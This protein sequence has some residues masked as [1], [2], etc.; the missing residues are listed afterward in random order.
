VSLGRIV[1]AV[2]KPTLVL[3][4]VGVLIGEYVAPWTEDIAQAR[5]SLA[6]G[7]GE[8][9]SSKRGLWHRQENEF[10]HVNAVQPGGVLVG[11][12]RYRFDDERRLLSASFAKRASYQNDHWLLSNIATTHFR[13]DHTEVAQASEERWDVQLTPQLLGIVV[14][15]PE[16]LS[17]TGL[18]RYIHYLADQ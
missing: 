7:A 5:R 8:A 14:V 12:T 16:S 18:W 1:V 13:G 3:L 11:V 6:Q 4:L 2:M 9:Q 15:A 17:I 10:V